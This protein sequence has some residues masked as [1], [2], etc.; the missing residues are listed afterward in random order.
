MKR[1]KL[2][3][4]EFRPRTKLIEITEDAVTVDTEEG[5]ESIPADTVI[6]AVGSR[7]ADNLMRETELERS[8]LFAIGDSKEPRN[9]TDAIREG[10]DLAL[11][12]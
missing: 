9:I 1:L 8:K 2:R 5:R 3:G 4:I 7:S 12:I 11:R 6:I 10:F